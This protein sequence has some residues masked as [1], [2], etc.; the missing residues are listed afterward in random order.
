MGKL[1]NSKKKCFAVVVSPFG[2]RF[3][4]LPLSLHI[5][6][7][8]SCL[9]SARA[10]WSLWTRDTAK[11]IICWLNY[12]T[13]YCKDLGG[14]DRNIAIHQ[15]THVFY[16]KHVFLIFGIW[17]ILVLNLNCNDWASL[18]KL[19]KQIRKNKCL[20]HSNYSRRCLAWNIITK[21]WV[22]LTIRGL[23]TETSLSK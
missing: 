18:F 6:S 12:V 11:N 8:P 17:S 3:D 7:P 22:W 4:Y 5:S 14:K 9:K 13:V 15:Q 21:P 10:P 16:K 1:K 20:S 23:I 19:K 2:S